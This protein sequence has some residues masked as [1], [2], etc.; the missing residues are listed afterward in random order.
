MAVSYGPRPHDSSRNRPQSNLPPTRPAT[1]NWLCS[2]EPPP[3]GCLSALCLGT[4]A[5]LPPREIA[6]VLPTWP[7]D[8]LPAPSVRAGVPLRPYGPRLICGGKWD[9]VSMPWARILSADSSLGTRRTDET[10]TIQLCRY[11]TECPVRCQAECANSERLAFCLRNSARV[12]DSHWQLFPLV[13]QWGGRWEWE[14][15][16]A[17]SFSS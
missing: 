15:W 13:L 1:P 11:H 7:R 9:A 12:L 3:P 10:L 14:R 8:P 4:S 5:P 17:V 6:F 2:A 16:P